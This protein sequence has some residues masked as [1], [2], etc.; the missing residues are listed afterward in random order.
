MKK[1]FSENHFERMTMRTLHEAITRY[2]ID[3]TKS[4]APQFRRASSNMILT[5]KKQKK[6]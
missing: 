6:L 2:G 5:K 1:H 3:I 4:N